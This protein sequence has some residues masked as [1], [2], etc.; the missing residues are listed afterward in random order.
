[1]AQVCAFDGRASIKIDCPEKDMEEA[2][3]FLRLRG[4]RAC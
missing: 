2:E 4:E 3:A 1:M